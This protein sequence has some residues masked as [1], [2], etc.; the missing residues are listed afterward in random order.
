MVADNRL[1]LIDYSTHLEVL[2][3]NLLLA[4]Q[5]TR[6]A[7]INHANVEDL[8]SFRC[9]IQLKHAAAPSDGV[10]LTPELRGYIETFKA[11][12]T[13]W[14]HDEKTDAWTLDFFVNEAMREGFSA[15]FKNAATLYRAFHKIALLNDLAIPRA[16]R[17]RLEKEIDSRRF[18]SRLPEPQDEDKVFRFEQVGFRRRVDGKAASLDYVSLSDGEHQFAQILGIFSMIEAPD[19][20]FILD[21]PE[22]HFNPLW[23]V[24]FTK[25]LLGLPNAERGRQEVLL[26]THAPFV[27]CDLPREQVLIFSREDGRLTVGPPT[28]ETFGASFD[29]ILDACFGVNPP[30][31]QVAQDIVGDLMADGTA[32]EIE[33]ALTQLGPSVARSFLADRLRQLKQTS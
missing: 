23:R 1:L 8:E 13:C 15:H 30:I 25:Q 16:A 12:A 10:K 11:L 33:V 5:E 20:L 17:R 21:E 28:I 32:A 9:V 7:I 14:R 29:R 18:A 27:P 19:A 2:V 4:A 31:S 6:S 22:S 24:Q 3:A 26:T